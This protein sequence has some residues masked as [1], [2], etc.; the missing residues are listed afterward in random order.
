MFHRILI[1]L[2]SCLIFSCMSDDN[3]SLG[4]TN[5]HI[6]LLPLTSYE[7]PDILTMNEEN[8]IILRYELPNYCYGFYEIH[9]EVDVSDGATIIAIAAVYNDNL[10]D[11]YPNDE[12]D[13]VEMIMMP[14]SSDDYVLKFWLGHD[15]QGANIYET[16]Q[17]AVN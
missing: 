12:V 15:S 1:I 8:S 4:T 11:C 13:E 17:I 5:F 3:T 2:L 9:E 16:V 6:E 7:V 10:L 14:N